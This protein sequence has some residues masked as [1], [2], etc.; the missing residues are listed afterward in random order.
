[1]KIKLKKIK[2]AE[3]LSEETTAFT[4]DVYVDGK[5]VGYAK[6]NGQ[7]GETYVYCNGGFDSPN[8]KAIDEAEVWAKAQ[9]DY[10]QY[11]FNNIPMTLDFYI[12]LIV[13]SY[14]RTKDETKLQAQLKRQYL[15]GIVYG[16]PERSA[17]IHWKGYTLD[18]LVLSTGS[19]KSV[20]QARIDTIKRDLKSGEEILNA[21]FL[22]SLG[23]TV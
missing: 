3:H 13:E 22:R 1:M 20:V 18:K 21:D 17:T 23:L 5:C 12:D 19:G 9:P 8:R 2:V 16:T 4:A 10:N 6:N 11:G 14:L 7:G 15:K